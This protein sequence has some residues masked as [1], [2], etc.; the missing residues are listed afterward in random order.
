MDTISGLINLQNQSSLPTSPPTPPPS[1]SKQPPHITTTTLTADIPFST[2]INQLHTFST[3]LSAFLNHYDDLQTHIN[4]INS[5]IDSKLPPHLVE[6]VSP[7]LLESYSDQTITASPEVVALERNPKDCDSTDFSHNYGETDASNKLEVVDVSKNV[8]EIDVLKKHVETDA[9]KKPVAETFVDQAIDDVIEAIVSEQNPKESESD[10]QRNHES[11]TADFLPNFEEFDASKMLEVV[12]VSKNVEEIDVLKKHAET[13]ALKKPVAETFVDQAINDVLEAI[14]SEQNPKESESESDCQRNHESA[15]ADFSPN[16]EEF[17]ASKKLKVVVVDVSKNCGEMDASENFVEIDSSKKCEEIDVLK[18]HVET[19]GDQSITAVPEAVVLEQK[20]N[21]TATSGERSNE[22]NVRTPEGLEETYIGKDPQGIDVLQKPEENNCN[23]KKQRKRRKTGKHKKDKDQ[24]TALNKFAGKLQFLCENMITREMRWHV[25]KHL[26]ETFNLREEII[27]ALKLAKDPA[28]LVLNCTGNFFGQETAGRLASVLVLECFVMIS[29]DDGIEIEKRERERALNNAVI[30]RNRMINEGGF[31]KTDEV[32]ARGLL[33]LISGFGIQDD[34]FKIQDIVDLI[35][36][37]NVKGISTALRRSAFLMPKIPDVISLMVKNNLEIEAVDIAYTFGLEDTCN[38][39]NILTTYLHNK[40]KDIQNDSPFQTLETMKQQFIDL[41]SVKQCLESHSVNPSTLLPDYKIN[42]KIQNLEKK[43]VETFGDQSITAVPEAVALEQKPNGTATSDERSNELNVRAPEGLEETYIGKHPQGIDVLQK[44][45]ENYSS[46]S[47]EETY[48]SKKQR[49]RRKTGKRKKDKDKD[50]ETASNK[51]EVVDVSKNV[52]EIDVLKKHAETDALKKPVAETFVDQA[53]NDVLEAIVSEQNPKES[54]SDCQRNHESATADF[55]PS[56]EEF[57]ASKKLE[58][59]VDVSKNCGEMGASE[60]F[61][62][63]D[64]SKKCEEIDVLKKHVETFGDQSITAFPEAVVLEQK[65]NGTATSGEQSNEINVRSPEDLE[66]TYIGKDPQGID[67]LQ[68]PEEHYSSRS[69]EETYTSKKRRKIRKRKKDKDKE[70]ATSGERSNEINVRI[71][72]GLEETY[73]GKDPQ[74]IDVLQKPEEN[75][76]SRSP[77]ETYTSKKQRKRRKTGK[78]K[79]DKDKE[80]ALN[81]FVGKLQFLC[82]NMITKGLRWHVAK[83]LSE[84]LNLR[85]EIIKA[86]K[87]A[88]DPAKLVLNCT[89]NF[90]G[91]ET[92]GRLASVL[93]L[94]CFVMISNDDGIEIEK[95]EREH[96]LNNAVIWRKRMI[97]EGG[98]GHTDEVDARGLLLLISGFGIQDDVFKIQDIVDLI[99]ASNVKGISTALRRS[100]FLM[101]KVPE[102]ISLMVKNN[103]EIE[104]VDMAYTFGLEDTSNSRNILTTYLHHKIKDIQNDSPFQKLEAMKQQLIDLKSVKQCLESHSVNPSTLLPDFKINEK[105][106]NLG[107]EVN[108]SKLIQK[109][110][111][112]EN[113]IHQEAKR[114]CFGHENMPHQHESATTPDSTDFL[115]NYEE[116][117]TSKNLV[118]VSKNSEE[119][120]VSENPVEIDTSNTLEEFDALKRHEEIDTLMKHA[121]TNPLKKQEE[122]VPEAIVSEQHP[123]G[124]AT[125]GEQSHEIVTETESLEEINVSNKPKPEELDTRMIPEETVLETSVVSV[126]RSFCESMCPRQLRRHVATHFSEMVYL[127]EEIA[128]ALK[129]ANDPAELVISSIGKFF[130][131]HTRSFHDDFQN[132]SRMAAV[133]ILE[134]FVMISSDDGI[135]I[136]K[137]DRECAAKDASIWKKRMIEDGGFGKTDEVDAR[138]LLLFISGFGIQDHVFKPQDIMDLIRASNWKGIS[139]ALRRSVFLM[140]KIPEVISLMVKNN[141][142]I[143]AV[144]MAYTFGLEDTCNSQNILTTYLHNKIK[145]IQNDSPFQKLEALK[146]VKQCLESHNIDPSTLLP[147]FKVN[148]EIQNLE[149][150]V[151]ES[152]LIQKRKSL[153]NSIHQEAKRACIGHES[154]AAKEF[155]VSKNPEEQNPNGVASN[156]EQ[157][158]G[159]VTASETLEESNISNKPEEID[160]LMKPEQTEET[161]VLKKPEELGTSMI[162]EEIDTSKNREETDIWKKPEETVPE[163]S[164]AVPEAIVS[165]QNPNRTETEASKKSVISV[166]QLQAFCQSMNST[167]LKQHVAAHISEMINLREEIVKALKLAEDP[168]KLVL[169]CIIRRGFRANRRFP[170]S[171]TVVHDNKQR[172]SRMAAVLI[173]ECFVMISSDGIEIEKSDQECAAKAAVDW[174]IRMLKEGGFG[175]TD[176]VDARGLLLFISGFGIQDH[177]FN[178]PDIMDL[179]RASNWKGISTALCR[180]AFL[181]PK[182]PWVI[183]LMLKNNLEVEAV[184]IAYTFGLED[185]CHPKNILTEYLNNKIKDFQN[186]PPFQTKEAVEQH[187]SDLKSVKQCLESHNVDPSTLLPDH[188]INKKIQNLEKE[189]KKWKLIQPLENPLQ[190]ENMSKNPEEI[191]TCEEID[192]SKKHSETDTS[193]KP[194]ETVPE[195]SYDETITTVPEA[196]VSE[197]NPNRTNSNRKRSDENVRTPESLDETDICKNTEVTVILKNPEEESD[198]P[199]IPEETDTSKKPEET[200]PETS[201]DQTEPAVPKAIVTEQ[202]PNRVETEA[203]KKSAISELESLCESMSSKELKWHVAANLS[204]M[205]NFRKE[206]AKALKLAKDPANLVIN[207]IGAFFVQDRRMFLQKKQDLGRKAAV[208]ILEWFVMI[209]GDVI[210]IAK[211]DVEYAAQAA[212]NWRKRMMRE[213]GPRQADEVDARGLLLLISGFGIQDHIFE[214]RDIVDLI[215]ASNVKEIS[216]ALR[217]SVF[218]VPKIPEVIDFMVKNNLEIEAADIAYTFGL[219]DKCHPLSILATF[220]RSRIKN[221]QNGSFFHMLEETKQQLLDLKSVKQCLE[222]HNIDPSTHL[223]DFKINEKIQNLEKELNEEKP[224]QKRKSLDGP[225]HQEAKRA[226][227]GHESMP[228]H[229]SPIDH[230]GMNRYH[231]STQLSTGYRDLHNSYISNYSPSSVYVYNN[232]PAMRETITSPVPN[233]PAG[234]FTG[235]YNHMHHSANVQPYGWHGPSVQHYP[236]H[237]QT[238]DSQPYGRDRPQGWVPPEPLPP[239]NP[240]RGFPRRRGPSS[241]LYSFADKVEKECMR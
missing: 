2:S 200:V 126:L 94:E 56:F 160:N 183:F 29:N 119:I 223:P 23:S 231:Q 33:L 28:K 62:G 40:I 17:D 93:M 89:G 178:P 106:Q 156:G 241:D 37:S 12:D 53:I 193:E 201:S 162:P 220:L 18:K 165:E 124:M 123:N 240:S 113:S 4:F 65:P 79:K 129:L 36:A 60:N 91:Q 108:E 109:R 221:I 50:K 100:A 190:Q 20:P 52:E 5:S 78:R 8:E 27:K 169:G 189:V 46:R 110:E 82:K 63:I 128:K 180:S 176:E 15:T 76:S 3:A 222:S 103:L 144:D 202:N 170:V 64:S 70:T 227:F 111:S 58:V 168:A 184:D 85:E 213:G 42:E 54:E 118:D 196:I 148:E 205:I 134:C 107:K 96:A 51:L 127:R 216:A 72:E 26:S 239:S 173:L 145:D 175:K 153:D 83:H 98:F 92:A 39:Q 150:E 57:D 143:E 49:K 88:K 13:D 195:T 67:V 69:P 43:H 6:T 14:V 73:I 68:K 1:T 81:K 152:K 226:C 235:S 214:I 130:V 238:Y 224:I 149:K 137:R 209:S 233:G 71:P 19:F 147:D 16:F 234:G 75:Y 45:E 236:R 164:C 136:V 104:A 132:L 115:H 59:V 166:L 188:K 133:L 31:G 212:V 158:H 179:M 177:V 131:S 154:K 199:M 38:S 230:Y 101:P 10:C 139:T 217:R 135:K 211:S 140:P 185:M 182:M 22:I 142:E 97:R 191:H 198:T 181:I 218:L 159:N 146:S 35:R 55:S 157:S 186:S 215:R 172:L 141:L 225:I 194:E 24:E 161:V 9:L 167:Q 25:A 112:L 7:N 228:P 122:T 44:P 187:L 207:S 204:E 138:G 232:T 48:T 210:E 229:Q 61:V 208:L 77:E 74:G 102:V 11:A 155:D 117:D 192:P 174:K 151:N 99:R 197:Q 34:V 30:W 95:R 171:R 116:I 80:T 125:N 41:K 32:D 21:G 120:D 114:A 237:V 105:I 47:P 90:F 121:E 86:L 219:E 206:L 66:V 163:T 84:M 87:L 203:S